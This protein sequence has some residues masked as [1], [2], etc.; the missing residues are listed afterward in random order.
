[1][2][3]ESAA[4]EEAEEEAESIRSLESREMTGETIGEMIEGMISQGA[5]KDREVA[6]ARI[7]WIEGRQEVEEGKKD[8][9]TP[10]PRE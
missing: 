6:E 10:N 1:M 3:I 8:T 4:S 2:K 7:L 5:S 9:K